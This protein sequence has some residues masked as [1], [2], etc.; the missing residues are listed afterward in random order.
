[1][2]VVVIHIRHFSNHT[3]LAYLFYNSSS[4][5]FF[6]FFVRSGAL[7]NSTA[8]T[9]INFHSHYC[10]FRTCTGNLF[11]VFFS[12][13]IMLLFFFIVI[14]NFL[15]YFF[16]TRIP[17][18]FNMFRWDAHLVTYSTNKRRTTSN[19]HRS[20]WCVCVC[21]LISIFVFE[22]ISTRYCR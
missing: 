1:M 4:F 7:E 20:T 13:K 22:I 21:I 15:F 12:C 5:I 2:H 19:I 18:F 9:W 6:I 8:V 3:L 17:I 11:F 10:T 16:L 14:S